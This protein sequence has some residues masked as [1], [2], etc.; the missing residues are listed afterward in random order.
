MFF[1]IF[2]RGG[3]DCDLQ[4]VCGD[5][6]FLVHRCVLRA[7]SEEID[8]ECSELSDRPK[9]NTIEL[10]QFQP[11]IIQII[12]EYVYTGCKFLLCVSTP[13]IDDICLITN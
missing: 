7:I 9:S 12:I 10:G 11:N 3:D 4:L 13:K 5:H 1:Y 6:T 2:S 8:R